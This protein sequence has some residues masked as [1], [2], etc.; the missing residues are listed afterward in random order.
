[1][2]NCES[3]RERSDPNRILQKAWTVALG[4][5]IMHTVSGSVRWMGMEVMCDDE[6]GGRWRSTAVR[7]RATDMKSIRTMDV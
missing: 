3:C 6:Y 5:V 1:M 2:A 4:A 7:F